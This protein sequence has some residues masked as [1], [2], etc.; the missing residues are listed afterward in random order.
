MRA[1]LGAR[2]SQGGKAM[3]VATRTSQ[4]VSHY[5]VEELLGSN[6]A[7]VYVRFGVEWA[8]NE[9]DLDPVRD[10]P[11]FVALLARFAA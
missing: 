9:P 7:F 1:C 11:R 8:A 2:P 10:D 6:A 3:A 5:R 4:E